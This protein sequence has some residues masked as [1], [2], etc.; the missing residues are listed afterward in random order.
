MRLYRNASCA[1]TSLLLVAALVLA[2]ASRSHAQQ[3]GFQWSP[4]SASTIAPD[5]DLLFYVLVGMSALIAGSIC[6]LIVVFGF[7]YR[8]GVRA[9]RANAPTSNL[10]LE[11]TWIIVPILL[12]IGVYVWAS[13][14]YFKMY[15]AP[16][17]SM[18]VTVVGKQWMWKLQHPD[19][20]RE[21][22]ELH[23]PT[24]RPV[25]LLLSSQDVIHSFFIP[26]MRVKQDAVPGRTTEIWFQA[27]RPGRYHL[28]CAQYCGADHAN[29]SGW[30]YVMTPADFEKWQRTGNTAET[31]AVTGGKLYEQLGCSGCHSGSDTVRA[32][33]L[34]GLYGNPV[35]LKSRVVV[36][37]DD[38]YIHDSILYPGDQ[39]VAGYQN[40]MPAYRGQIT[41]EQVFQLTAYIRSLGGSISA[42]GRASGAEQRRRA[43]EQRSTIKARLQERREPPLVVPSPTGL[44]PST[45][46]R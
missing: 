3:S 12:S 31:I 21:I 25:R 35:P 44:G 15:A 43:H 36:T 39:L 18:I 41:E 7:R 5:V 10:K 26:A 8:R 1:V 46:G 23:V 4:E 42:Q 34:N 24:G 16:P 45:T 38:R 19:G 20:R 17:D 9:N 30:V 29:M 33:T 37:A 27:T 11:L 32:P 14:L 2:C 40:L 13:R 28:F 22:D 6:L